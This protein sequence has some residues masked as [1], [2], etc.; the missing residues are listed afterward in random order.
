MTIHYKTAC[1]RPSPPLA[2]LCRAFSLVEVTLAL[3]IVGFAFVTLIGMVPTGLRTVENGYAQAR[4]I[5]ILNTAASSVKGQR[6]IGASGGQSS[7]AFGDWLSDAPDPQNDPTT[8]FVTQSPWENG[9]FGIT[10]G[11]VIRKKEDSTTPIHHRM[12]LRVTPP[13]D[14]TQPARIF[15]SVAW[16]GTATWNSGKWQGHD[17][18]VEAFLYTN[19]PE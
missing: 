5:E 13:A 12:F 17:G 8:Y 14:A 6:Y 16:P 18:S 4:A 9:S 7:Y 3:G 2:P 10:E 1:P 19:A 11:G 15:I